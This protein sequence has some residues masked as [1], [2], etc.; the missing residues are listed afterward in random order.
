[1]DDWRGARRRAWLRV[2][3]ATLLGGAV[4]AGFAGWWRQDAAAE[5][6]WMGRVVWQTERCREL[7]GALR[8]GI[9]PL[10]AAR[11]VRR[12]ELTALDLRC[13]LHPSMPL[14]VQIGA[15]ESAVPQHPELESAL[16]ARKRE[17]AGR[18]R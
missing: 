5:G 10:H 14:E 18:P 12:T 3:G 15:L 8:A 7:Q 6:P 1:M 9:D 13:M 2:A 4:A 11:V 16:A 17:L